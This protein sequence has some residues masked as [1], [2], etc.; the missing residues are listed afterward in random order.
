MTVSIVA[1]PRLSCEANLSGATTTGVNF[2]KVKWSNTT[3]S[4]GTVNVGTKSC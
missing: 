2:N 4:N 1:S 3:C